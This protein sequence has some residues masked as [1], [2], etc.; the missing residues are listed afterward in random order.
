MTLFEFLK[1][2]IQTYPDQTV[3]FAWLVIVMGYLTV[4]EVA[5]AFARRKG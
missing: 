5:K 1:W 3:I 4:I 2:L